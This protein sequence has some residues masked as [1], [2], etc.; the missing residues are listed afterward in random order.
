MMKFHALMQ[1][2]GP[3]QPIT[4]SLPGFGNAG[5]HIELCIELYKPIKHLLRYRGS[6]DIREESRIKGEGFLPEGF[7]IYPTISWHRYGR[8]ALAGVWLTR[9]LTAH[10]KDDAATTKIEQEVSATVVLPSWWSRPHSLLCHTDRASLP[11]LVY[12]EMHGSKQKRCRPVW[13]YTFLSGFASTYHSPPPSSAYAIPSRPVC[14]T[15]RPE[16]RRATA[17]TYTC[18]QPFH[19]QFSLRY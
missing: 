5:N 1:I 12:H 14:V 19:R 7:M 13:F 11:D 10:S 17:N 2:K 3:H 15:T 4:R 16:V 9:L 6:I 8:L 18:Y